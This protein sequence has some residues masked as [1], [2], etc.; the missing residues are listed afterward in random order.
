MAVISK[1]RDRRLN[2]LIIAGVV[3]AALATGWF[4]FGRA[5]QPAERA[6]ELA[7]QTAPVVRE[8]VILSVSAAGIVKPLT[9]VNISPK[10]P[11]RLA[12]LY[13]DQGQV[14]KKGQILARMDNTDL[15]GQLLQAK[16]TLAAA[17]AN[18]RKLQAGNRTQEIRQ[19]E[20]NLRDAEAQ[21]IGARSTY[22]SNAQLFASGAVS[23]NALD[24][25][26]SQYE[27]LQARIGALRQQA[28]LSKAGFRPEDID[29]ARAQVLQAEGALKTIQTQVNDTAIRA[30]F[31]GVITQKFANPG[32][33]VTPTTSASATSS[34]T[35]SSIL[36]MAGELEAV[37]SVAESDVRNIYPG[38]SVA[39]R[40]D[41]YPG[42][43]F[44]G[45]VRL[46]APEAVVVQNVTSFEVRV[47]ITDP[48]RRLLKSGMNLTAVFR[49]GERKD[50]LL[51][52]TTAVV[53]EAGRN[54]VYLPGG[55]KPRFKPIE[56]GATVGSQT[57]VIGGLAEGDR[58]YITF[59]GGR[60]PNDRPVSNSSPLGGPGAGRSTRAPR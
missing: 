8:D 17:Q 4:L 28:D 36:A 54:G 31:A 35:S 49:V 14:V 50:A 2:W 15:Q 44:K 29:T 45:Q 1:K 60:K 7:R 32:S 26:R 55:A 53:S 46:V 57:Q 56:I 23:R 24:V 18:L 48:D 51:I 5:E 19:A 38:Q 22:E 25:S 33:F 37:A 21:L 40:V 20:Q 34:A 13:V 6:Q 39:L 12:A 11:G 52:P 41:A 27:S 43:S 42:R 47:R 9:P 10:Q 59:P 30:P 58:V 3:L 16:G